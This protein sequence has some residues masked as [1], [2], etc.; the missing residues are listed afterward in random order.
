MAN[1]KNEY[2]GNGSDTL[3]SFTFP[4]I[5]PS[6]VKVFLDSVEQV[7]ETEY[8][9]VNATTVGFVTA[10]SNG[11]EIVIRRVTTNDNLQATFFPGSA[12]RARDLNDNFTQSLYATQESEVTSD[13]AVAAA[14]AA[15]ASASAAATSATAA[16]ASASQ[17]QSD[18]SQAQ[19]EAS[20]AQASAS[21][22]LTAATD[23]QADANSAQASADQ[24]ATD[25]ANAAADAASVANINASLSLSGGTVTALLP[26]DAEYGLRLPDEVASYV[27]EG[28]LRY[29]N[30]DD[31]LEINTPQG[32][33]T[34]AGGSRIS[35]S[36]PT[37]ASVGDNWYDPD[38]GRTYVYYDDGDSVQWV[39][40]NP[41]WNGYVQPGSV[42]PASLSAGGPSW[43]ASGNFGVG[44]ASPDNKLSVGVAS[45]DEGVELKATYNGG[46]VARFALLNPG[47]DNTPYIGSVLGND[48][49]FVTG[50]T[51][52]MTLT[53][54]GNLGIGVT[55]PGE[56]LEINGTTGLRAN[57]G[58]YVAKFL[59]SAS[60]SELT[61]FIYDNNQ[62]NLEITAYDSSYALAFKTNNTER[63]R[64]DTS[65][66]LLVGTSSDF[67]NGTGT[68]LQSV[69]PAGG[70]LAIGRDVGTL[71]TDNLVGRIRWYSNV[72]GAS[73][74]TARISTEAD[75]TFALGD[76]PS[77]LVFSTNGGAPDT[78]PTERMR[79]ASNG[80]LGVG[81]QSPDSSL[82]V[83][84]GSAGSVS[85]ISGTVLTVENSSNNYV[86]ILNPDSSA[87]ALVYGSP[88]NPNY[89][90][91]NGSYGS[92]SPYLNFN[93]N[94]SERM[95]IDKDG[96]LNCPGVYN[97][98]T[99]S[100]A[101]V[102]ISSGGNFNRAT[103][104]SKYKTNIE[105]LQDNYADA[106]LQ[107][108]PVWYQSTSPQDDPDL[109]WWGF[110]AEEVAE[111]DPRLVFWKTSELS[112]DDKGAPVQTPLE[113]PE[114][115]G[116]QYDRFVPHL[117][118]LIK[119]QKEQI[120]AM[121]TR[122]SQLEAN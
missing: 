57:S 122:I 35:S 9:L 103:S 77:R 26:F 11:S 44:T 83:H 69:D 91:V 5:D 43:D 120:E 90:S 32:W 84:S 115:E 93:V 106:I 102:V 81:T 89:A 39:E 59:N 19:T 49:G 20:A 107:C 41:S 36:P 66:R 23:A 64:L 78:S 111:V 50:N 101:N 62:D 94:G 68:K 38:T 30:A 60:A 29:N 99:A 56:K 118:N 117:L 105:T 73:E 33:E 12:I 18:A 96:V 55:A 48:F 15:S 79:L 75:S 85:A 92:G 6:H 72:G 58:G 45:A 88:S 37:P 74:E 119:R 109:G 116:V 100:A 82:H 17:A 80:R 110:I 67:T 52:K 65:G 1:V 113:T 21:S 86:S 8:T 53:L 14:G 22:A 2:T 87:G 4:Y 10:P 16:Q 51:R 34:A 95:R 71:L 24:A 46:R 28:A 54:G 13:E 27:V 25:A 42:T 112:Y 31:R 47:V 61:G 63:M 104:S 76:K 114:P 7:I 121:E 70:Q 108:R 98:T 40:A 97:Y 3:F